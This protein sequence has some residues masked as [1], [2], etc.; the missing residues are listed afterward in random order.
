[1]RSVARSACAT[2]QPPDAS[3]IRLGLVLVAPLH[4]RIRGR[5]SSRFDVHHASR[6]P[7]GPVPAEAGLA[8]KTFVYTLLHVHPAFL[9]TTE[10][11]PHESY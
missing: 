5:I 9:E 6:I 11:T 10:F 3:T 8:I 1:M 7:A 2:R 4:L